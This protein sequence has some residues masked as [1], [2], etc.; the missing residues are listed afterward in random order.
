[1]P[2]RVTEG[3]VLEGVELI[4]D[5]GRPLLGELVG[6]EG[7]PLVGSILAW[8][9][10]EGVQLTGE[11]GVDGRFALPGARPGVRYNLN[12]GADGYRTRFVQR[13]R[14]PRI[15]EPEGSTRI[16]LWPAIDV[17][18]VVRDASTGAPIP[19]A[20]LAW[21]GQRGMGGMGGPERNGLRIGSSRI[22]GTTDPQGLHE[23]TGVE[24]VSRSL[25]ARA[26][27][28]APSV[29]RLG[30]QAD[31]PDLT[32][33][34]VELDLV[35]GGRLSVRVSDLLGAVQ[36]AQL[37]LRQAS[38]GGAFG[39]PA[40]SST[41]DPHNLR[42]PLL[43]RAKSDE[44]GEAR[45][46]DLPQDRYVLTAVSE[47][48]A[49]VT[50]QRLEIGGAVQTYDLDLF[51]P[52][53]ASFEG[54]VL[55]RGRPMADQIVVATPVGA[56]YGPGG[57]PPLNFSTSSDAD[58]AYALA[59]LPPGAYE[60]LAMRGTANSALAALLDVG[61]RPER[62]RITT[63]SLGEGEQRVVDLE[64]ESDGLSLTG[65]LFLNH[66]ARGGLLVRAERIVLEEGDAAEA[67]K[68]W[69]RS[70]KKPSGVS[71]SEGLYELNGLQPGHYNV[72]VTRENQR[73]WGSRLVQAEI[74]MHD[75]TDAELDLYGMT[76][77][78]ELSWE[79]SDPNAPTP[80]FVR[81]NLMP[82]IEAG[83]VPGF[84]DEQRWP[85]TVGRNGVVLGDVPEGEYRASASARG[86]RTV[87][88]SLS[89]RGGVPAELVF[90]IQPMSS[91]Q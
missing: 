11:S 1:M 13:I 79:L 49:R 8:P 77:L 68:R 51:L 25:I 7:E 35:A 28:Y 6:P 48:H 16:E 33:R 56:D 47:A 61:T 12:V 58:G 73:S 42:S 38:G 86:L 4:V 34:R 66:E 18:V 65:T 14:V 67:D 89:L 71:D 52:R 55:V 54:R 91:G 60:L 30:V 74:E 46:L 23:L 32:Q 26:P 57:R 76:T 19:G 44:N 75:D 83:G 37:E 69:F 50:S 80:R 53:A 22:L 85:F 45:F 41:P 90:P 10:G 59:G 70:A 5:A 40:S 27:G 24:D 43:V 2:Q 21:A 31:D 29:A 36:D 88:Q 3:Q 72:Y 17:L 82:D 62:E 63:L 78:L 81:V 39:A 9:S 87:S 84:P 15:E 64:G 20:E